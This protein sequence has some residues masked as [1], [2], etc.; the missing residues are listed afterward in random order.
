MGIAR[1]SDLEEILEAAALYSIEESSTQLLKAENRL[2]E[3]AVEKLGQEWVDQGLLNIPSCYREVTQGVA[4]GHVLW[5]HN[6][7]TAYGMIEVARD[8]YQSLEATSA[9]WNSKKSFEDNI[10]AME[11]GNPGRA[12]HNSGIDL[13][14]ILKDHYNPQL[15]KEK[16]AEAHEWLSKTTK[17]PPTENPSTTQ[18]KELNDLGWDRAYNLTTWEEFPSDANQLSIPMILVQNLTMGVFG[19][20]NAMDRRQSSFDA[21]SLRQSFKYVNSPSNRNVTNE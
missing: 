8:R 6:L 7:V 2:H 4:I 12:Y 1:P 17:T 3:I 10:E 19:V 5:L 14:K 18:Q 11:S 20:N 15:V 16:L 9:K 13:D 21:E